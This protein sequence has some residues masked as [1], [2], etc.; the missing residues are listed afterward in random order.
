MKRFYERTG[1]DTK[2]DN[3]LVLEKWEKHKKESRR[4]IDGF[5]TG[6]ES[7]AE[8]EVGPED[9]SRPAIRIS[10]SDGDTG[11]QPEV[12]WSLEKENRGPC[13]KLQRRAQHAVETKICSRFKSIHRR[14]P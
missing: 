6:Y 3:R 14:L 8:T 7:H 4:S 13:K 11:I 9:T 12:W 5:A 2:G 1:F 10:G